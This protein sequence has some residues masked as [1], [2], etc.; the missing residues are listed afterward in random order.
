M[1]DSTTPSSLQTSGVPQ[2]ND[3][4]SIQEQNQSNLPSTVD[5]NE[6]Q[7]NVTNIN[8]IKTKSLKV[9]A[10]PKATGSKKAVNGTLISIILVAVILLVAAG[11]FIAS[12]RVKEDEAKPSVAPGAEDAGALGN[13]KKKFFKKKSKNA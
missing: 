10:G 9:T 8:D 12:L 2:N 3:S 4:S 13:T 5:S 6:L 7:P 1:A 11:L